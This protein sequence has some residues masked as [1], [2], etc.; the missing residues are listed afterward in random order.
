MKLRKG[1]TIKFK[2]MND[3]SGEEI[4]L[5]GTVVGDWKEVKKRYPEEMGGIDENDEVFLVDVP[6]YSGYHIVYM[7]EIIKKKEKE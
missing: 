3:Y 1:Q 4:E 5:L 6:H 2:A 7:S